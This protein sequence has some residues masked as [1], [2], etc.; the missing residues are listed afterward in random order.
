MRMLAIADVLSQTGAALDRGL[1]A[2]AVGRS[3]ERFGRNV[4]TAL[5]RESLWK[6]FLEK[7]EDPIIKILLAAAVVS[8]V[9]ELFKSSAVIA[10]LSFGIVAIGALGL[11]LVKQSARIPPLFFI[12]ALVIFGAG[13]AHD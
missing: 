10:G 6:K 12:S 13:L 4:L 7:F 2:E 1:T 9:V 8:M 11:I 3:R 5:P